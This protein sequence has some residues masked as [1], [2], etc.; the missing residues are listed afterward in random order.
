MVLVV[1]FNDNTY[2][3]QTLTERISQYLIAKVLQK[4]SNLKTERIII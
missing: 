2:Y 3:N 1:Q 4:E